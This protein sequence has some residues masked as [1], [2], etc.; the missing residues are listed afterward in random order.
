MSKKFIENNEG[1]L[2]KEIDDAFGAQNKPKEDE[3]KESD[4]LKERTKNTHIH[5]KMLKTINFG[6]DKDFQIVDGASM[7]FKV[8]RPVTLL[9]FYMASYKLKTDGKLNLKINFDNRDIPESRQGLGDIKNGAVTGAFGENYQPKSDDVSIK[10]LYDATVEGGL[11]SDGKEMNFVFGG[12]T[13]PSGGVY[14]HVNSNNLTFGKS[15]TW[16]N[17]E[18]FTLTVNHN[19][20]REEAYYLI[21]YNFSFDLG[22]KGEFSTRMKLDNRSL[23]ETTI[24]NGQIDRIGN[25]ACTVVKLTKGSHTVTAQYQFLGG[26]N[27]LYLFKILF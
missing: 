6:T 10:I 22:V 20:E 23:K 15:D 7:K 8:D 25:H 12:I 21:M 3:N 11:N 17:I 26:S 16:N 27:I 9:A 5:V 2:A 13:F 1:K 4:N 18:N 19:G 14:K 24:T